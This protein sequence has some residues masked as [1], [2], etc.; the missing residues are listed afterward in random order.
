MV[1][2]DGDRGAE[3]KGKSYTS[4]AHNDRHACITF[5]DAGVDCETDKEKKQ[6]EA[7]IG[8]EGQIREGYRRKD[9]FRKTRYSPKSSWA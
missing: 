5:D 7:D 8:H 1:Q 3:T 2:G 4:Q 6:T 9:V